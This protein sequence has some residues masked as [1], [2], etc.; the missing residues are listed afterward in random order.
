[1]SSSYIPKTLVEIPL[2]DSTE[3]ATKRLISDFCVDIWNLTQKWMEINGKT[4]RLLQNLVN[5]R[6]VVLYSKKSKDQQFESDNSIIQSRTF[7]GE[8]VL[9]EDQRYELLRTIVKESE[10]LTRLLYEDMT[11]VANKLQNSRER[12]KCIRKLIETQ[13]GNFAQSVTC[14]EKV[15]ILEEILPEISSMY[16]RELG[17][18]KSVLK[19]L[20]IFDDREVFMAIVASWNHEGFIDRSLLSRLYALVI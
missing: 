3:N 12:L 14:R 13:T 20:G 16:Q 17:I 2:K 15:S 10:D 11:G 18:K 19:D 6:L 9:S 5:N 7:Y 8:S 4:S 1:M